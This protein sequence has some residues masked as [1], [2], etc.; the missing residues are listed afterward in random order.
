MVAGLKAQVHVAEQIAAGDLTVEVHARSQADAL[1]VSMRQV[2][3]TL[4]GLEEEIQGL[5]RSAQAGHLHTRGEVAKFRGAFAALVHGINRTLDAIID[6]INEALRVLE[7]MAQRDLTVRMHGSY[8]GDYARLKDAFN[9][10]VSVLNDG[11][12]QMTIGSEQVA[13]ASH[14]IKLTSQSLAQGSSEQASTLEE[15]TNSLQEI[16]AMSR[17]NA[18]NAQEAC[19]LA[20]NARHMADKGTDTMQ[21]LSQA[22]S[23][24]KDASDETVKIVKTIDDIAFQTNLLA[25]NAAVEAARAGDAGKGFAVVAEEVRNLAMRSAEAARN[26]ATIINDAVQ[27]AEEGV[28]LNEESLQNLGDIVAEVHRVNTVMEEIATASKQQQEGVL[29][30][31]TAVQQLNRVT[32]QTA[33]SSE[34][35]A[36]TAEELS[37]QATETRHL[38]GT[39]QLQAEEEPASFSPAYASAAS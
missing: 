32:Q 28:V 26:T 21:R 10:A 9:T 31:N 3:T 15:I 34:E 8:E 38:V 2:L 11:L 16:A 12:M 35:A 27:R 14:Q 18:T 19:G 39:F 25:L 7:K 20:G 17:Q 33:A 13:S 5:V 36:S 22:I 6:P 30:V 23:Q 24:M 37:Y 4:R 1:A 29:Q